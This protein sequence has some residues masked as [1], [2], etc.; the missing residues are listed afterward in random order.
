MTVFGVYAA[1]VLL[2]L[3]FTAKVNI[4]PELY[5]KPIYWDLEQSS[6]GE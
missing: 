3:V 6:D 2:A 4:R 5:T 1:G